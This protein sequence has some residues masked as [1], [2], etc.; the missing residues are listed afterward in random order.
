MFLSMKPATVAPAGWAAQLMKSGCKVTWGV[1][2][3]GRTI[4]CIKKD[5]EGIRVTQDKHR[6]QSTLLDPLSPAQKA[7]VDLMVSTGVAAT[8]PQKR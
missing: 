4:Y 3:F 8:T 5:D 7:I 1:G 2:P 6:A